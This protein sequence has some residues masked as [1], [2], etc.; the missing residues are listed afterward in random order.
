MNFVGTHSVYCSYREQKLGGWLRKQVNQI[1]TIE[2]AE[3]R[4]EWTTGPRKNRMETTDTYDFLGP[5][6]QCYNS[7]HR[8]LKDYL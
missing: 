3:R 4:Q 1:G 2:D 8:V 5:V 7:G 6:T